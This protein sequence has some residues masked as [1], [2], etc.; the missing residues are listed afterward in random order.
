MNVLQITQVIDEHT[1]EYV[2]RYECPSNTWGQ[3]LRI[4]REEVENPPE[5]EPLQCWIDWL[6]KD[7]DTMLEDPIMVS[8]HHTRWLLRDLLDR[9][10][11]EWQLVKMPEL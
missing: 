3:L 4:F 2:I 10:E 7:G 11:E 5:I 8:P 9:P 1:L 6:N